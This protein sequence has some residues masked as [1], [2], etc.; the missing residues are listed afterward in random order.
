MR[1]GG[2]RPLDTLTSPAPF[3]IL[4]LITQGDGSENT[5]GRFLCVDKFEYKT[6]GLCQENRPRDTR[7]PGVSTEIVRKYKAR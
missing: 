2:K 5:R 4:N 1:V 6:R 3:G 7:H